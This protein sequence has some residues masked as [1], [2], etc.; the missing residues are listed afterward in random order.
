M[1]KS[2]IYIIIVAVPVILF[3][4]IIFFIATSS[5]KNVLGKMINDMNDVVN[6]NEDI[7]KNLSTKSA[8]ISKEGIEIKARAIKD[9]LTEEKFF[10]KNCRSM[11]R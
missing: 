5:R 2:L 1:S 10:C 6:E 9:G 4:P 11:Y 8:N 7:L 3:G